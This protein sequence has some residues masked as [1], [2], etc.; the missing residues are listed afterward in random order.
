VTTG[1]EAPAVP[2]ELTP[3]AG[4]L[5]AFGLVMEEAQRALAASLART[6]ALEAELAALADSTGTLIATAVATERARAE[7]AEAKAAAYEN[8]VSWGASCT[9]CAA[10][11]DS[12]I[13]ETERR[14]KAEAEAAR[15]RALLAARAA[16]VVR[17]LTAAEAAERL[18]VEAHV[19]AHMGTTGRLLSCRTPGGTRRYFPAE[20][21]ALRRGE[22]PERA[23]ELGLAE[24]ARAAS[25]DRRR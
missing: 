25:V 14:E 12:C 4:E 18:G 17:L 7:A 1:A 20:V 3:S 24:Q 11:L 8:A 13:E 23:R 16:S 2:V 6:E 5:V 22:A 10:L 15:L 21:D 19:V 9:S